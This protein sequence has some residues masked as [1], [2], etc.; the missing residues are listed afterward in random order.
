MECGATFSPAAWPSTTGRPR[1]STPSTVEAGEVLPAFVVLVDDW[2]ELEPQAAS[3]EE[4]KRVYASMNSRFV[5]E[6]KELEVGA[7]FAGAGLLTL[8]IAAALSVAWFGRIL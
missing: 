6:R 8:L 1:A 2:E 5:V 7:L 3:T 4:L